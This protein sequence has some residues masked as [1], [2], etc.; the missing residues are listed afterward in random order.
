MLRRTPEVSILGITTP[1]YAE[2][3]PTLSVPTSLNLI[4]FQPLNGTGLMIFEARLV[5]ALI[6]AYFGGNGRNTKIEG[7]DFTATENHLIQ[8]L[9]EQVFAGLREAWAPVLPVNVEFISR[10]MNPQ[11]AH[12]VSPTDIVVVNR[13]R[14][15]IEGR[16]GEIHITLPYSMLEP[17]KDTLR[18][19]MQSDRA[20]REERWSQLLRN[21][22]EESEVELVTHLGTAQTT[23]GAL[24]DMRPGDIVPLDFNGSA[25]VLSDGVP[26]F[27][28]QIGQQRGRQ[29]VR[30]TQINV[31]KTGNSLDTFV[32]KSA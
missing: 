31:R 22:L 29:V 4:K 5:F 7:R 10:E 2:Y 6:D 16:G 28:G 1:K 23:V 25:V 9:M 17:M 18:A 3:V 24:I 26:L 32:R 20:D 14:V 12:I 30:V 27:S 13:L 11:F 8:M 21:E 19:G 15:D